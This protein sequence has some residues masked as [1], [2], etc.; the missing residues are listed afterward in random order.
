MERSLFPEEPP[1]E[2]HVE[3]LIALSLVPGIG[4]GRIR[5]LVGR[6]GSAY[7]A[8]RASERELATVPGIGPATARAIRS[9]R[10]FDRVREQVSLARRVGARILEYGSPQ[11]P[12]LLRE[13]YDP[14]AFL[15]VR[16]TLTE[17]DA[18]SVAVVGTRRPS[19]YGSRMTRAFAA[20]LARNGVTV[21]SGLAYGIDVVA[22]RAALEA[23]GRT[24]AVLGSGVD[25][26]YPGHHER[27]ASDIVRNGAL[28]SEY[29]LGAAPD[30]PNFPRRNRVISGLTLGTLVVEAYQSGGALIT[31]REALDQNRD[32]FAIP[33]ALDNDAGEGCNALI[34]DGHARLVTSVDDILADLGIQPN[35]LP[36]PA[37]GPIRLPMLPEERRLYALLSN[38]PVHI[39]VLCEKTGLDAAGALVL[40]LTMEFKGMVRQLAGKYF[41]RD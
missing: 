5:A 10:G 17:M 15:W 35:A 41:V 23:G 19:D 14:P 13:T 12:A 2:G 33:S 22:H 6:F 3:A 28:L 11:Y 40:L 30:A 25:R 37:D 9:F 8:L 29:P 4:S 16:G 18:Q 1:V 21:V 34:R 27:L 32:V 24:I 26:I 31:A 7:V 38:E 39:D 20:E 36:S